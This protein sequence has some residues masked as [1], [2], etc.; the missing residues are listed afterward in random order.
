M[1]VQRWVEK[2]GFDVELIGNLSTYPNHS[3]QPI[4]ARGI[5][6]TVRVICEDRDRARGIAQTHA[7]EHGLTE[8][9]SA[10]VVKG[11]FAVLEATPE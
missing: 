8:I 11:P 5:T 3:S 7:V 4:E 9:T 10:N 1:A 6:I 2:Q